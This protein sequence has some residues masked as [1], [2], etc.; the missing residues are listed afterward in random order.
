[1]PNAAMFKICGLT[2]PADA[3]FAEEAG[4]SYVGAIL[5]EGSPRRVSPAEASRIAA[6]VSIPLVIV[7]ADLPAETVAEAAATARAGGV[8]LQ[9]D[10]SPATIRTLRSLG[11]WELWKAVRVRSL[12][13]VR[14]GLERF[15]P[16][17]DLLL[18]DAWHPTKLGGTGTSFDWER[19][20]PAREELSGGLRLGVAGG[21]SPENVAEAI[22]VLG[23]SLVDVSSGVES[24][25]GVKDHE[26]IRAFAREVSHAASSIAGGG[27][28]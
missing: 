12:D 1:M 20:A 4:A 24:R 21:L 11:D 26:R 7:T 25:P 15:G 3:R 10:E 5:V 6:A 17:V 28:P 2:R 23:P 9:G 14:R 19:I 8:Q 18:L 22:A 27:A 16:I 13:D